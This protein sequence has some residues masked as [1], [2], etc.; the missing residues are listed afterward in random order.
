[1][2]SYDEKVDVQHSEEEMDLR[3]GSVLHHKEGRVVNLKN[4]VVE[5]DWGIPEVL[6]QLSVGQSNL[7]HLLL[8]LMNQW[9]H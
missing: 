1:M 4:G 5:V 9:I 7:I 8:D 3:H 2:K 6:H